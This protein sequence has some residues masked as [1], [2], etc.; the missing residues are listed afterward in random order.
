M[1]TARLFAT[2]GL[3]GFLVQIRVRQAG[4][5]DERRTATRD[6]RAQRIVQRGDLRRRQRRERH[7]G[8]ALHPAQA[9]VAEER[10]T[11][12]RRRAVIDQLLKHLAERVDRDLPLG[13]HRAVHRNRHGLACTAV[14]CRR[15]IAGHAAA[16]VEH[17]Q[18][19]RGQLGRLVTLSRARRL[20]LEIFAQRSCARLGRGRRSAA[21]AGRRRRRARVAERTVA[22]ARRERAVFLADLL[23]AQRAVV[24]VAV[25]HAWPRA[26]AVAHRGGGR[27][28]GSAGAD[29]IALART[30]RAQAERHERA[31]R[32]PAP[33]PNSGRRIHRFPSSGMGLKRFTVLITKCD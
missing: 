18:N 16:P 9:I 10:Q 5:A 2:V 6:R 22:R 12:V 11:D 1:R 26:A 29:R 33:G 8:R 31:E 25:R 14:L 3:R 7:G 30:R 27:A 13:R 4:R 28:L 15:R 21:G 32:R 20:T 19:I 24:A 17:E 23:A